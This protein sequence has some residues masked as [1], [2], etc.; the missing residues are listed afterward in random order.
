MKNHTFITARFV[1]RTH[2]TVEALWR[3]NEVQTKIRT[4]VV[5]RDDESTKWKN[6]LK[7]ITLEQLLRNTF[8]HNEADERH[9]KEFVKSIYP[10][11]VIT[12]VEVHERTVEIEKRW[13]DFEKLINGEL[14]DE[15]LFK[16]KILIFENEV[17][18]KSNDRTMK[19]KIRKSKDPLEI[20]S[21]FHSATQTS[22]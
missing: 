9:L 10:P 6:L 22:S 12:E 7:N 15:E 11:E 1:D 16:L 17:M 18:K 5:V 2:T 4:Q 13:F 14:S 3:D 20:L 21:L 8:D 19:T